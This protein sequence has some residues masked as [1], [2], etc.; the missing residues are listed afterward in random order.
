MTDRPVT[1]GRL[2]TLGRLGNQLWQVAGV[3]GLARFLGRRVALNPGWAYRPFL[4]CPDDWFSEDW[5]HGADA[6]HWWVG[7]VP[8]PWTPYAQKPALWEHCQ[9]EIRA[10]FQPSPRA[11]AVLDALPQPG[12][13]DVAVHVRRTDYLTMPD[14]LPPVTAAY[15]RRAVE[16]LRVLLGWKHAHELRFHVYGDDPEWATENLSRDGWETRGYGPTDSDEPVD[17]C[18]LLMMAR[19]RHH[20]LA[21]SS[22][23]WWAAWL[24]GDDH[25]VA[26]EPWFGP[27][28]DVPSPASSHWPKV[29]RDPQPR[30]A[31]CE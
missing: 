18:D 1:F 5:A 29:D 15:Y 26:P 3:V 27:K 31:P 4:S 10:A 13:M 14:H 17:W 6:C 20:I 7:Q 12:P 9:D 2:G 24:S 22:Y 23:S 11:V 30:F 28:I 21:N 25:A 16:P 8:M 19:Y